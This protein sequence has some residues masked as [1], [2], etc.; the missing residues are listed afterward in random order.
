MGKRR[1]GVTVRDIN[2]WLQQGVGSGVE[3]SYKPWLRVSDVPSKGRSRRVRG[4]K[5]GRVHHLLS[6]LEYAIFLMAEYSTLI[7]DIREQ[8][9]LLP[10]GEITEALIQE[11][12][13]SSLVLL[14]PSIDALRSNSVRAMQIFED[15]LPPGG[16]SGNTRA[17]PAWLAPEGKPADASPPEDGEATSGASTT[18]DG[19]GGMSG[20][21]SGSVSEEPPQIDQPAL[22]PKS[23]TDPNDLRNKEGMQKAIDEKGKIPGAPM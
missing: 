2:R 16:I 15:L 23:A 8:F 21:G 5:S 11:C 6:D 20:D 1:T 22:K 17:A 7:V 12:Y 3:G 14:H 10:Y 19:S 18:D 9:P 13:D 4:L